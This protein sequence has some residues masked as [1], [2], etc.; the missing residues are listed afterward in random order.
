[1][2]NLQ[3]Q[4]VADRGISFKYA[5]TPVGSI[6]IDDLRV[7]I[8]HLNA[9]SDR[10]GCVVF[11][12]KSKSNSDVVIFAGNLERFSML[13]VAR[14]ISSRVFYFQDT[15]SWWYGGSSLL[16]TIQEIGTF[17]KEQ[18]GGRRCLAFGQSSGGYAALALGGIIPHC[19]ILAC[20]PQ[21]FPDASLKRRL[22]ISGS[23]GVQYAPDH[24]LDISTLYRSAQRSGIAAAVFSASENCNPYGSHFWIDHL[25]MA[26]VA[27]VP[28]IDTYVAAS[29]NHSIVF[30]RARPFS[31]CLMELAA[32]ANKNN[33]IKR[34]IIRR[35]VD[36]I[37]QPD[38]AIG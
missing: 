8:D 28:S 27:D 33:E 9:I 18:I 10:L 5:S 25:H 19:D 35:Y 22:H 3:F 36:S 6:P 14:H 17:L 37:R 26:K 13:S 29:A 23:L 2:V 12:G 15:A 16:P 34:S 31:E 32:S 1:L 38:P 7:E 21:T 11:E 24:I 20:S 4:D 30:Q